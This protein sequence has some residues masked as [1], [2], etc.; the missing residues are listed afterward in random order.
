M[1]LILAANLLLFL[2]T[3]LPTLLHQ[4]QTILGIVRTAIRD[5]KGVTITSTRS[6][7]LNQW[8]R[9]GLP[10]SLP[11]ETDIRKTKGVFQSDSVEWALCFQ[12]YTETQT[13]PN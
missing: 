11:I 6:R 8:A 2:I 9:S 7:L 13:E 5:A 12:H 1:K 4:F 3:V 10:A